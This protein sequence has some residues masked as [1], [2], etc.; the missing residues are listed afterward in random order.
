MAEAIKVL[1]KQWALPTGSRGL[2]LPTGVIEPV[3][4]SDVVRVECSRS[5]AAFN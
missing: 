2:R 3:L 4:N 1:R 5:L